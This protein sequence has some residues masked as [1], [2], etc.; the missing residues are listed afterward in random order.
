M[1]DEP[2]SKRQASVRARAILFTDIVGSTH[3]FAT[4]GDA[5]GMRMLETHNRALF[6]LIEAANG[7]VVKTIGDS[8]FAVFEQ[9]TDAL[10]AAWAMQQRMEDVRASLGP[11]D[12]IHIREGVHYGLV[13]ERDNDFFGDAVN[14]AERV[15]SQSEGDR[16]YA[17]SIVR[18]MVRARPEYQFESMGRRELK[19]AAEPVELFLLT[20]CPD[21]SPVSIIR[22]WARRTLRAMR[23]RRLEV[24]T[25]AILLGAAA[26]TWWFLQPTPVSAM[27]VLPF[28]NLAHDQST[29]Y[30]SL[31]LP[32][33]LD[34]QLSRTTSVIIRPLDS[35]KGY[36]DQA[37]TVEEVAKALHVGTVVEG[38]FWRSGEQ[39]RVHV[40]I[41]DSNQDREIW[42]E[43]FQTAI[44]DLLALVDQMVPQVAQALRL[45]FGSDLTSLQTG[46]KNSEAYD[47][48]LRGIA[49]EQDIT[50]DNNSSAIELLKKAVGLDPHFARAFAALAEAYV[51][52]FWWNFSNDTSWLDRAEEAARQALALDPKLAEAHNALG[53]ALE[54]K[55]QRVAAVR[56]YLASVRA[57]PHYV[58]ALSN[59]ARYS[60]YMA[61]FPR[62]LDTLDLV[63]RIDP[64]QNV[65][66]RKAMALYFSGHREECRS[67]NEK[68]EKIAQ[69][70]DQLTLTAFTYAWLKDYDSADRVLKRL[71]QEEPT[72]LS[73]AEVRC[74]IFSMRGQIPQARE[75]MQIIEKRNTFG[76]ADEI[77]TFYAI[78]GDRDQALEWLDKAVKMGAPNYAWY[79]SDFFKVCRGDSRY[80]AILKT[81]SDEYQ[82]LQPELDQVVQ[83]ASS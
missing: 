72:A 33:E 56:E 11:D 51:T 64:T 4:H 30:L 8:I 71:E 66:I 59:V 27:A 62:T 26:G 17:S 70:V 47:V 38:D 15:M 55:G 9:P 69:G 49:L 76:I 29:D 25:V 74:W 81:L 28:R 41:I 3:Y 39:L 19:G 68:A 13:N 18:D 53:Y 43:P 61:N 80:D 16:V 54:G 1:P 23:R 22:M 65:H 83:K 45:R 35:V 6:P 12:Q 50:D 34:S 32:E 75:Q 21:L 31:A 60:F 44:A 2:K 52:R 58:P 20:A 82:P 77:A 73:I 57:N 79:S 7:R 36:K 42:S 10:A 48:Y 63:Y 78:Q 5:A 24:A 37:P 67:E 14:L 46:T 40:N